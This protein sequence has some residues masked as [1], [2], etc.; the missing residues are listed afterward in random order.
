MIA[1][2]TIIGVAVLVAA[3]CV[4]A[5]AGSGATPAPGPS[6]TPLV[7]RT[8]LAE[9]STGTSPQPAGATPL[10]LGSAAGAALRSLLP[11]SAASAAPTQTY[12]AFLRGADHQSGVIDLIR[13]DDDLYLDLRPENFDTPYIIL[14]SLASGVGGD[15]FAGRVYDPLVVIFKR[16][17]KRVLWITP[18]ARYVADKGTA[19]AQS[20]AISVADTVLFSTPVVAEDADKAHVVVSP[21]LFT[22]DFEGIGSDLGRSMPA[23]PSLPGLL[24]L[25]VRASFAVDASKSY[26]LGTKSFPHNDEISV[27]LTFN[28]PPNALPTVPDGRGIPIVVHYSIVAPPATNPTYVPRYA[29]DRVGYFLTERKHFGSD[30]SDQPVERFI[31]RWDISNGPIVFTLTNEIPVAYRATVRRAILAWNDAFAQI[32][33]PHAIEVHDPPSDPHFDP[34]DARYNSVRWITSESPEFTAISPHVSDP[35]TGQIIRA[36]VVIDGEAMRAVRRG[37]VDRVLP[38]QRERHDAFALP[39]PADAVAPDDAATQ[40]DDDATC[41]F[42]EG[43]SAQAA[44]GMSMLA[45]NPHA[46]ALD[47]EAYAQAYLFSVV[48]HEVGHTLGLR[49]NFRGST[50]FSY[51]EEHDPAFVRAHGTTGSVMDYTPANLAPP[52]QAQAAYFPTRLGPYDV[53]AIRYGYVKLPATSSAAEVPEL[54]RIASESTAPGLGYDTDEDATAP[55]GADPSV[56]RFDLSSDPLAF[57][58][59]QLSINDGI[60]RRLTA[61]Y[62]GDTRSFQDL[63]Q[64]LVTLLNSDVAAASVATRFIGGV[65]TSR[66]HRGQPGAPLPFRAVPRAEQQ[67]AFGLIDRYVLSSHAL[68]FSPAL[69]NSV[70]ATRFDDAFDGSGARRTDFPIGEIAAQVQDIA[71]AQMFNPTVI[72]RIADESL[73]TRPGETMDLADLFGWT[74]AALFD[75]LGQARIAPIHRDVQRRFLDLELEIALLPSSTMAQLSLPRDVQSIARFELRRVRARLDGAERAATDRATKA[76]LDDL[77]ER[78]DAGLHAAVLRPL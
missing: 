77:R 40:R 25:T 7:G 31:D 23:A 49:H 3:S 19:A 58:D 6:S 57:A 50:A 46:S 60:A 68:Q 38:V 24:V 11:L 51:A 15:A 21:T 35:Q 20:L 39:A 52:G 55:L 13:K 29:D 41:D 69:L 30:L 10:P 8:P 64:T 48:I 18:N 17:G 75:D 45:A 12:A 76:D 5:L 43:A 53:W 54:R 34:D 56:Q 63:R 47:R 4:F 2:R 42:A 28:G 70:P 1:R 61:T 66:A 27:N 44:I 74:N 22:S 62:H 33:Y 16:V 73:R 9:P 37:F 67:R 32:G 59:A 26:Y 72:N 36:T 71:L 65:Y 78:I 14:P